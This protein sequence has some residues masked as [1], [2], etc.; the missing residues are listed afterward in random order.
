M[1]TLARRASAL[2]RS[3]QSS[4][5]TGWWRDRLDHAAVHVVLLVGV[6]V[7]AGPLAWMISTSLKAPADVFSF[8]PKWIPNPIVWSNYP[9]ALT[10]L[11]FGTYFENT[12]TITLLAMVGQLF[13]AA[14]VAFS[15]ARLRWSGRDALFVVVLATLMLPQHVTLVPQYILFSQLRLV[16]TFLPLILP[17]YFGGGAFFIFLLRQFFM[18]I[19]LELDDAARIDGCGDFGIFWRIILPQAGPALAATAIFSFQWHWNDFLGPLIYLTSKTNFTLALGLRLFQSE[20]GTE[21]HLVM[22][23]SVVVMLPIVVV[24]FVAQKYFFQGVVFTGI[25]G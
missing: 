24:F 14:L 6:V 4:T 3:E 13:S 16:D 15:F 22:A 5:G 23:A 7:V 25:K 10:T 18:T 1:S 20:M 2:D 8:P 12:L 9:S 19:P 17:A 11:P 21:W